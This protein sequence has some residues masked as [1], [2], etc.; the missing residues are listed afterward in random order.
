MGPPGFFWFLAAAHLALGLF[1]IY[2]MT[3]RAA[4]PMDKQHPYVGVPRTS[5]I[6]GEIA[7]KTVRDQMDRDLARTIRQ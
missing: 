5:V 7:L 4:R 2:R 1:A 3:R 6:G